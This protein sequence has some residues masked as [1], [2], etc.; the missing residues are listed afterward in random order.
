MARPAPQPPR[1]DHDYR[2][3]DEAQN[4]RGLALAGRRPAPK[5]GERAS[6]PS[7]TQTQVEARP[8]Q[9]SD[10]MPWVDV[11]QPAPQ[12]DAALSARQSRPKDSRLDEPVEI[13]VPEPS[14]AAPSM[15]ETDW[16]ILPDEPFATE[17]PATIKKPANGKRRRSYDVAGTIY[18]IMLAILAASLSAAVV[19][20]LF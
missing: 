6:R 11:E 14:L 20:F 1:G 13:P 12:D 7:Q 4:D 15:E 9:P 8:G 3:D 2:I 19:L 10:E 16:Q 17:T 18:L 5:A